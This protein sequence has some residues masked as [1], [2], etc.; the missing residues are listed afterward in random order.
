LLPA[1]AED[2]GD[3]ENPPI[4]IQ[5]ALEA[6][7]LAEPTWKVWKADGL[8]AEMKPFTSPITPKEPHKRETFNTLSSRY[9]DYLGIFSLS[10]LWRK[11]KTDLDK[12]FQEHGPPHITKVVSIGLGSLTDPANK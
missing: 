10:R 4:Y 7:G 11:L 12:H 3:P 8:Q 2:Y 1:R 6:M 9:R 5:L